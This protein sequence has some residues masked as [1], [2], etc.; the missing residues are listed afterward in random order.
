M[1]EKKKPYPITCPLTERPDAGTRV[2]HEKFGPGVVE[3]IYD[4]LHPNYPKDLA[5][6]KFDIWP[7]SL[8]GERMGVDV[9]EVFVD[10]LELE[11]KG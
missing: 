10:E 6:V 1:T 8:E 3:K 7:V 4:N 11:R 2:V 9:L 5:Y